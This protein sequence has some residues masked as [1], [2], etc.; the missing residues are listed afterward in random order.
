MVAIAKPAAEKFR[1]QKIV[2]W[3]QRFREFGFRYPKHKGRKL[4]LPVASRA[5]L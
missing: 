4:W 2:K 3:R 1:S 5:A